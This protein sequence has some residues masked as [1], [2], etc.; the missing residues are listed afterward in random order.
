M[1]YLAY[2]VH[3]LR[4]PLG[5]IMF[6]GGQHNEVRY[7]ASIG[8]TCVVSP[9]RG[10]EPEGKGGGGGIATPALDLMMVSTLNFAKRRPQR[11]LV[12]FLSTLSCIFFLLPA[13]YMSAGF[14]LMHSSFVSVARGLL[15]A[16]V[17]N[18]QSS[19][20]TETD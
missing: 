2:T 20:Q 6:G 4:R 1:A 19:R 9:F 18:A 12:V 3:S 14:L 16:G 17:E 10:G 7:T 5:E 11:A 8:L 13:T 15:A